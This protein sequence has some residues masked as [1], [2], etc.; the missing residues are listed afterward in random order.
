VS[1]RSRVAVVLVLVAFAGACSSDSKSPTASGSSQSSATLANPYPGYHSS[2][3]EGTT[4]W[5]CHPDLAQDPCGPQ[6]ETVIDSSGQLTERPAP[7]PTNPP[8]DCFYIYPTVS[9][10]PGVNSDLHPDTNE[11]ATVGAQVARYSSVCR[12]FA[13]AYRQVTLAGLASA[14]SGAQRDPNARN[15]AYGD[16]LDAWK[17]Y[18]S[19][20]N[21]GRGVVLI[22]HSQGTGLLVALLKQ[23]IDPR[24]DVRNHIVSAILMGGTVGVPPGQLVGGDLKN[25][26]GCTTADQ[27]GCVITFSSF[28]EAQPPGADSLFGGDPSPGLQALCVNPMQLA[29]DDG[30]ADTVVPRVAPLIA[31]DTA[32]GLPGTAPYVVLPKVLSAHCGRV[33]NKTVLLYAPASPTDAR[34]VSKLLEERLGPTWG[35][36]LNDANLPQDNLISIV[37]S[38]A[39]AW[40][41]AHPS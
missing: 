29:G 31:G 6:P 25:I 14:L 7:A 10:D 13:P 32:S 21:Q 33:N 26:P 20:Y 37:G 19:Q 9:T 23:E 27:T 41:A 8:I 4:N 35:L 34:D 40:T 17:T 22:G 3:Y 1:V 28:P 15:I 39:T 36:H 30:L 12:V 18:I 16:V 11:L 2:V 38:E 5:I 24:P